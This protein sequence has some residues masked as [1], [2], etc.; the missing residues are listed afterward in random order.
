MG[1]VLIRLF[2]TT[3]WV[4]FCCVPGC[5]K[6]SK[7]EAH[8]SFFS[9]PHKQKKLLKQWIHNIV[10]R[11]ERQQTHSCQGVDKAKLYAWSAWMWQLC[12]GW[13]RVW[14]KNDLILRGTYLNISP[15]FKNKKKFSEK[16]LVVTHRIASLRILVKRAME[17]SRIII[18]LTNHCQYSWL[19]SLIDCFLFAMCWEI[20]KNHY[21][22][23]FKHDK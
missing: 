23:D 9:I 10:R 2:L 5:P 16:D 15:F 18:F 20:F 7:R 1:Y 14:Y 4:H 11:S 3:V 12:Y 13:Q 17:R 8:L 19:I 6:N 21:V 22:L